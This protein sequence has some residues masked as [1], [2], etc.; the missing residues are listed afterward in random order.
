[1]NYLNLLSIQVQTNVAPMMTALYIHLSKLGRVRFDQSGNLWFERGIASLYPLIVAHTDT[2]QNVNFDKVFYEKNGK[3]LGKIG[4]KQ[5]GIGADDKN[6]IYIALR[7]IEKTNVP[8]KCL[9]TFGEE[10]GAI[11]ANAVDVCDFNNVAYMLEFD[12]KGSSDIIDYGSND[13]LSDVCG[14]AKPF[15]YRECQGVFTDVT[16]L[17]ELTE[18]SA[19]NLSCGYYYAHTQQ[20]YTVL[21]EM[22]NAIRLGVELITRLDGRYPYVVQSY[23]WREPDYIN[24][25][26]ECGKTASLKWSIHYGDYL[27]PDCYTYFDKLGYKDNWDK[28]Y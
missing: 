19:V 9:F 18:I 17:S 28:W 15:G 26:A 24:Q 22:N 20:E 7:L 12:R 5:T 16:V 21:A 13:F 4:K 8:L 25:C 3:I 1:M 6:G 14:I 27:C 10:S 11:G 2:V 23:N